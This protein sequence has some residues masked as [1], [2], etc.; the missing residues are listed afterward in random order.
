MG[1]RNL[2]RGLTVLFEDI[3][4]ALRQFLRTPG[5]T[6]RAVL[7]LGIGATTA[8]FTLVH[9]V[10]DAF[11]TFGLQPWLGRLF[12]PGDA[13][14]AVMNYRAWQEKFGRDPSVVGANFVPY[15]TYADP[16]SLSSI[17]YLRRRQ[18]VDTPPPDGS[19]RVTSAAVR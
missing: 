17:R 15:A 16:Q 7:A 9:A 11:G 13:P 1:L 12:E 2:G 10:G 19:C 3:R 14:V 8:I 6:I 5:F 4:Y 18:G